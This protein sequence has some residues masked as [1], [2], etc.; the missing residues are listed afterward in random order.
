MTKKEKKNFPYWERDQY[1]EVRE[2]GK[3]KKHGSEKGQQTSSAGRKRK[4]TQNEVTFRR[5]LRREIHGKKKVII[6]TGTTGD[7]RKKTASKTWKKKDP[8]RKSNKEKWGAELWDLKK[9][10]VGGITQAWRDGKVGK[11]KRK[12]KKRP[13]NVK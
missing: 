11:K 12:R 2:K 4:G 8:S 7:R 10:K 3:S 6:P 1:V 5:C 13:G 9:K